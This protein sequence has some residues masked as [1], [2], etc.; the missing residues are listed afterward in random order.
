MRNTRRSVFE[1]AN[2]RL[3]KTNLFVNRCMTF[4]MP[5]MMLIMNGI[6]ILIVYNGAHA[7]DNGTMQVGN[8]MAFMQYAMQIIMSFLMITM[9]SIMLPRASV[10]AK[11]I[12]EVMDTKVSILDGDAG[13]LPDKGGKR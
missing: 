3:T 5:A 1:K 10:A 6:T 11:R 2:D 4:M 8:M 9:M 13:A 7:V 12:N